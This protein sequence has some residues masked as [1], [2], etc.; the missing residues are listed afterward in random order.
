MKP[1][2]AHK[3]VNRYSTVLKVLAGVDEIICASDFQYGIIAQCGILGRYGKLSE[4]Y[5][6]LL[7]YTDNTNEL[8]IIPP[9]KVP[10][11]LFGK[12]FGDACLAF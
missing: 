6:Q 11:A 12:T 10:P 4:V 8:Y 3:L 5:Q 7:T 9:E 2:T 1:G